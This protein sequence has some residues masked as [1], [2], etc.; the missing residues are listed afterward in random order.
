M[1]QEKTHKR[2]KMGMGV[3]TYNLRHSGRRIAG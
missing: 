1:P 2:M 3:H